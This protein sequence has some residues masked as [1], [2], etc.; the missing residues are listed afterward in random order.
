MN[1]RLTAGLLA[2]ALGGACGSWDAALAAQVPVASKG[3]ARIRFVDYDPYN[4]VTIYGKVGIFT[5]ILFEPD[6]QIINKGSGDTK[7]WGLLVH[8]KNNGFSIKPTGTEPATNIQIIT[9]K[10][11]YNF[12]MKLAQPGKETPFWTVHFRY[13]AAQSAQDSRARETEQVKTL[14]EQGAPTANRRYSA[15][16]ASSIAPVEGWDDGTFT[17]LRFAPRATIPA[18]YSPRGDGD[19]ALDRIENSSSAPG[20]VV[21]IPGVRA[22]LVLRVGAEIACIYNDAYDPQGGRTSVTGT[23]SPKVRRVTSQGTQP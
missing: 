3:D 16:G 8:A 20:D 4:V 1:A 15:E 6:E 23:V 17:Y 11:I 10:R 2:C 5:M 9:N 19:A 14:L 18:I 22:K 13:P 21:R 7:A 12:D